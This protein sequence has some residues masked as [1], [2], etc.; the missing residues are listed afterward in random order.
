M[1]TLF[2]ESDL[3]NIPI[4]C[5]YFDSKKETFPVKPHWHYYMEII[6]MMKGNAR[7]CHGKEEY[8]IQDGEMVL[9]HPKVIHSIFSVDGEAL[10]FTGIKL[11]ISRMNMTSDYSPKLRSIFR[12]SEMNHQNTVFKVEQTEKMNV[13]EIFQNCIKEY[14][15]KRYCYDLII[16]SEISKLLVEMIRCWQDQGLMIGSEV[17]SEDGRYDIYNI[18][19]Y[20]DKNMN[21]ELRVTEI[22][23]KCQMSYSHFAKKFRLVYHESCK[24]YIEDLRIHKVK[25]F[26]MF[27]DF[28]LTYISQESGFS[29]S[30]HMIKVFKKATG[31]TP[32]EYRKKTLQLNHQL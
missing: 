29:D 10:Y 17:Y 31:F 32:K 11:D 28:D 8:V 25:N 7:V 16:R 12:F 14:H 3:V 19:E 21:S 30:S 9:F 2:E 4:E 15:N 24:A 5:F 13:K 20:I 1:H 18:T 6:Y 27:T 22:A 26:L 23:A